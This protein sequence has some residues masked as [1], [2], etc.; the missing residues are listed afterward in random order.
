MCILSPCFSPSRF[1]WQD[2]FRKVPENSYISWDT[3]YWFVGLKRLVVCDQMK[4][5]L[6][7]ASWVLRV[8]NEAPNS[9]IVNLNQME[10]R[11]RIVIYWWTIFHMN[12]PRSIHCILSICIPH[13]KNLEMNN[14]I[15]FSQKVLRPNWSVQRIFQG[16]LN[17]SPIVSNNC[18]VQLTMFDMFLLSH[19]FKRLWRCKVRSYRLHGPRHWGRH[20]P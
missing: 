7:Q 12:V 13:L 16:F 6:I 9:C 14:A 18:A 3:I 1:I 8:L 5:A 2:Q 4:G 20:G 15:N 17:G 11:F 19:P 10:R